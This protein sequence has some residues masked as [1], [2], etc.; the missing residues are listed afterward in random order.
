M[1]HFLEKLVQFVV[2]VEL[3]EEVAQAQPRVVELFERADLLNDAHGIEVVDMRELQLDVDLAAVRGERVVDLQRHAWPDRLH[4]VVEIVAV[5]VDEAA[6]RHFR[7]RLDRFAGQVGKDANDERQLAL[8][9]GIARFDV[10]RDLDT[11]RSVPFEPV[12]G[13]VGHGHLGGGRSYCIV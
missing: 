13:T 12:L 10:V 4:H 3:G 7:Q 8:F 11:R 2:A 6:L 5:D 1:H 9:D